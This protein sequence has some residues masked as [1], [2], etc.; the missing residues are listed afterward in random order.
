MQVLQ[1]VM[2]PAGRPN[3][4]LHVMIIFGPILSTQIRAS[5]AG[6]E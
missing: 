4:I 5:C 3:A 1:D 2:G 6:A